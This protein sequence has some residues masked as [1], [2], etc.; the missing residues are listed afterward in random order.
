MRKNINPK[1]FILSASL[2]ILS[3]F[4]T[5]LTAAEDFPFLAEVIQEKVNVR[6]GPNTNFEKLCQL[7][8][9]DEMVVVGKEFT[10]YKIEI[11]IQ[12]SSYINEKYI[13]TSDGKTGKVTGNR[14][15]VRA[16][17]K[18]DSTSLGSVKQGEEVKILDKK[19]DWYKILPVKNSF[20]WVT[21]KLVSF[22]SQDVAP[23]YLK[24]TA[25]INELQAAAQVA[26]STDDANENSL[27]IVSTTGLLEYDQS[28]PE[29]KYKIT[30]DGDVLYHVKSPNLNVPDF[31]NYK[32][33]VDGFLKA[34]EQNT[35]QTPVLILKKIQLVL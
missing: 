14:V 3:Y 17:F 32:V 23:F 16:S 26:P 18:V 20:A 22:K 4:N 28:S 12:A 29:Y 13:E 7:S 11:P 2:L 15:N 35:D 9:G 25:Q 33:K 10:W 21:D 31:V 24:Q 30:K 19:E 5:R 34:D 6:A 8:Q 27:P 1:I